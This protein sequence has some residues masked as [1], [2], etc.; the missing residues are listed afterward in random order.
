M[1]GGGDECLGSSSRG[2]IHR[3]A[4]FSKLLQIG[5]EIGKSVDVALLSFLLRTFA[6]ILYKNSKHILVVKNGLKIPQKGPVLRDFSF[7]LGK[8]K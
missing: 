4:Y 2:L 7:M 8:L 5:K 3:R 1:F 6:P